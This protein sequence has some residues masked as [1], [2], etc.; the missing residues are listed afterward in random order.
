MSSTDPPSSG[1]AVRM[2]AGT[3]LPLTDLT[4]Y[5]RMEKRKQPRELG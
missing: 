1:M 5:F 4:D 2:R 3:A